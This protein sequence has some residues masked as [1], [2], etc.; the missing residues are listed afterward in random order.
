MGTANTGNLVKWYPPIS[1]HPTP[2]ETALHQRLLFDSSNDHDQAITLLNGKLEDLAAT[3]TTNTVTTVTNTVQSTQFPGLGTDNDQTGNTSYTTQSSDNGILLILN[4]ASPVAVSLNSVV[5]VPFFL[6]ATNGGA[7]TVTFTP[8]S[9]T[10]N[11]GASLAFQQN[12][13]AVI[14]FDGTNWKVYR[15]RS[16]LKIVQPSRTLS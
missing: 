4:D 15:L 7:G 6:F 1:D 13:F 2:E 11:G 12:Y 3:K 5:A 16:S 9:G 14:V 10:I 8:T